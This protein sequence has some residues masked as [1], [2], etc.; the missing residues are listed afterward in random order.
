MSGKVRTVHLG[1][2]EPAVEAPVEG[3]VSSEQCLES[4]REEQREVGGE[5]EWV[6]EG[7]EGGGDIEGSPA[8]QNTAV[9]QR[10]AQSSHLKG[11]RERGRREGG[12]DGGRE[13]GGGEGWREEGEGR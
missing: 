6:V 2:K 7:E 11:E 8:H 1:A 13:G 12:R 10:R 9:H 3:D 4:G 5:E